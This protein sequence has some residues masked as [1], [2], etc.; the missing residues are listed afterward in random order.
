MTTESARHK[1]YILSTASTL[2]RKQMDYLEQ[3]LDPTTIGCLDATGVEPG[4]RCLDLG[5]GG[6]SITRWLAERTDPTG[7]VVAVD[8]DIDYLEEQPGVAVY[9]H[10]INAGLP[11]EGQFDLIHVRTVLM[12]L[13][14]RVEI[15][16]LLV[17]ALAPGGW[18]VIG[19]FSGRQRQVLSAPDLADRALFERMQGHGHDVVARGNGVD[20]EWAHAVAGHMAGAGLV[21]VHG[22]EV[23]QTTAGGSTGCLLHQN[24]VLQLDAPLRAAGFTAAELERYRE[25]MLDPRF[26]AWFYQFVCTRGQKRPERP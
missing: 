25:L 2:G 6:G 15:F 5:A 3:L 17:D 26:H 14:R 10:D 1:D 8:L 24:Y 21:R 13:P 22:T 23:S 4:Q 12:H 19:D 11:V 7:L 18:L 16:R 9:Q 20:F